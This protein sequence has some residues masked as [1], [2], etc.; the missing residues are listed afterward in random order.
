MSFFVSA[1]AVLERRQ[2]LGREDSGAD[3]TRLVTVLS[4]VTFTIGVHSGE[5]SNACDINFVI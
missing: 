2:P 3:R 5:F 1:R 4:S